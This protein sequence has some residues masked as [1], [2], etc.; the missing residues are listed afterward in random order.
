MLEAFL[1]GNGEEIDAVELWDLAVKAMATEDDTLAKVAG[2]LLA[3]WWEIVNGDDEDV[4][5]YDSPRERF[6]DYARV[7]AAAYYRRA[8]EDD[9]E[10]W[11]PDFPSFVAIPKRFVRLVARVIG[12][13][14]RAHSQAC[15]EMHCQIEA[16]KAKLSRN[17]F[18]AKHGFYGHPAP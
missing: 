15:Y 17:E 5:L 11:E 14:D 16:D 6:A 9:D 1:Y 18:K 7:Y 12:Q 8:P 4:E 13:R 10:I 3:A 2:H